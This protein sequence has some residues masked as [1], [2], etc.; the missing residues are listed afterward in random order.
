MTAAM[1]SLFNAACLQVS[2]TRGVPTGAGKPHPA[3]KRKTGLLGR[4]SRMSGNLNP[5]EEEEANPRHQ[6]DLH[7][8]IGKV[9]EPSCSSLFRATSVSCVYSMS[10]LSVVFSEPL[11]CRVCTACQS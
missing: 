10:V 8:M 7:S 6:R 5:F 4:L 2:K 3:P 11:P 1:Q 9:G